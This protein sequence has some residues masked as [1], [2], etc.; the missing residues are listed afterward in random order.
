MFVNRVQIFIEIASD[1]M[2]IYFCKK[3]QRG[4]EHVLQMNLYE[5]SRLKGPIKKSIYAT[6]RGGR[7]NARKLSHD[8]R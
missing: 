4:K 1:D 3:C 7:L 5:K 8:T 2:S 6:T